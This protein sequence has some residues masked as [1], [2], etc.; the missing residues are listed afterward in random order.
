MTKLAAYLVA[1]TGLLV[2]VGLSY[3]LWHR[4]VF[5]HGYEVGQDAAFEQI[6]R[7]NNQGVSDAEKLIQAYRDCRGNR[8]R[9]DVTT[10]VCHH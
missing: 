1:A 5:N 4:T 6:E 10:G 7:I 9:W 8:G 3:G 2:A